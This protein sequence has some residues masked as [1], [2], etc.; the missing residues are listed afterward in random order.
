MPKFYG[1]GNSTDN[2]E[3]LYGFN[4]KEKDDEVKGTGNQYD[5]V[6]RIYNAF[7]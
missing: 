5:Y 1:T 6:F 4:G 3:Y 7:G 2:G